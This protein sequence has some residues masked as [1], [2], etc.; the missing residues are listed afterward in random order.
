MDYEKKYKEAFE[1]ARIWQNH[2]Y[3]TN[4]RDYAD[5]LNYIFP[6][7]AESEDEKTRKEII[8]V[9]KGEI[10][11]TS[12]ED[13]QKYITW[14]EKQG[15][16]KPVWSENEMKML[17]NLITYLNGSKGLLEETKSIYTDW[18]ES[19]KGRMQPKKEWSEE[20]EKRLQSCLNILQAKGIMGVT[21][22]INTKWLKS[23][24]Q[25]Y[26]WKPNEKQTTVLKIVKDYVVSNNWNDYICSTLKD[27]LEQLEKL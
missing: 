14:L 2:L 15:E 12:E 5:E 26:T 21:E 23:F 20:D 9:F 6:E 22:T 10:S 4:D 11:Y 1:R 16:Q 24:K 17:D 3:E 8:A 7:L 25:R 19:L 27:L 18:L 13:A